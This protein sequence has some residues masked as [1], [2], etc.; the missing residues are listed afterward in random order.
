MEKLR[1]YCGERKGRRGRVLGFEG[2]FLGI[3]NAAN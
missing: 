3:K 2:G 1:R